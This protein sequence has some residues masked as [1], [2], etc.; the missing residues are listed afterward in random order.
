MKLQIERGSTA[1]ILHCFIQDATSSL[2]AGL[3]AAVYNS[4]GIAGRWIRTGSTNT[5]LSFAD[6]SALATWA[7]P[8]SNT[9]GFKEISAANMPGWYEIHL[10]DAFVASA[11]SAA[12][13]SCRSVGIQV[14]GIA[15]MMPLNIEIELKN[16]LSN[17]G[18]A[19][20]A[21]AGSL[22]LASSAVATD[23][24]YVGQTVRII[25]GTGVGQSRVIT[26]YVG[27]TRVATVG[28]NWATT[29][30]TTS[31]YEVLNI[32]NPS[33]DS[34]GA[35][36][37]SS[38]TGS[39]QIS[40]SSGAVIVQSGTGTGQVDLS[41]GQVKVQ[42]GTSSGQIKA[43]SG[44]VGVNWGDVANPTTS[45]ALTGTT[46]STS[47][48]AASVTGN[49][50]GNVTGTVA[51]VVGAVGSVTGNVGGNV[52][53]S[54][55]SVVGAVGSVTGNVGGNVTGSVGSVVGAVGSV[56]GNVGGNVTGSVG[57]VASGGIAAASIAS[58]AFTAAKFAADAIDSNAVANSAGDKIV[59]R[60][61][62]IYFADIV[63]T[64]STDDEYT[65]TWF[66]DGNRITSGITSPTINVV[67]RSDGSDLV[68]STAMTQI[69]STASYKY[70][71]SSDKTSA[72]EAYLVIV[73]AT[74][75]AG[76]RSFA[77]LI[78]RDSS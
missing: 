32:R 71:E 21:A 74:I 35:V 26:A 34:S 75:D 39:N 5:A 13:Y 23:S 50:G 33:V 72:G 41:S 28:T 61:A 57:S 47:Q 31:V 14:R 22:T 24:Y 53:G 18:V 40:L 43:T 9:I 62:N 7:D 6:I 49:V 25:G 16:N 10:P 38:G 8:G 36:L 60:I 30:D 52:T 46:I 3:T 17:S 19:A 55:G 66:K 58:S 54:V 51:S 12:G 44:Y 76:S 77:R 27:S 63:F 4:S 45:L 65:V 64:K 15:N 37:V 2:G 1:V 42:N 73:G 59:G 68:A 29:P 11:A 69:G 20:A 70:D 78:S 67:K 56:T 48:V